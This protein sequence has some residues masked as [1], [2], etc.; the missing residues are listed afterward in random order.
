MKDNLRLILPE[1][2]LH[3]LSVADVNTDVGLDP[4]SNARQDKIVLVTI[5]FQTNTNDLCP[6]FMEPDAEPRAFEAGMARYKNAAVLV[7]T[8]KNVNHKN[9]RIIWEDAFQSVEKM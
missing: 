8:I 1:D 5:W 6:H 9:L 3:S 2:F 4:L 7:T